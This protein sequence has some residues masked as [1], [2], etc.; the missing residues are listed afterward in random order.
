M[1]RRK[2]LLSLAL[3]L[4]FNLSLFAKDYNA[5]SF[6]AKN[7]G[8][9]LN[10]AIIQGAINYITDHG[11]GRLVFDSGVY[12]TG[13]IYIKSNVT[14]HL[15][16]GAEL[17]SSGNPFD[18]VKDEYAGW[19]SMIF[20]IKQHDIGI[21]GKGTINGMGFITANRVVTYIHRGLINDPLRYDRPEVPNRP[22]NIY[23]RECKNVKITGVTLR[24]PASWNQI[25][26]QCENV[27]IDGIYV[28]SK[29]YWNND[30]ID[31]LNCDGVVIKNSYI[32]A[33]DD[34]LCFKSFD[35][36]G[37]CQNV[38]VDS[39]VVRSSANAIKF[40]TSSRGGFRN[41]KIT[42]IKIFDTYRS[43]VAIEAVDGG[44]VENILID[45]IK[46]Y[47]VGNVIFLRVGD[48]H[49]DDRVPS[50]SN[51][52]IKNVYAEVAASKP[53]S[54]YNYEGPVE[55]LPRN[56]SPSSIVGL[57]QW[58][59]KNV[60]LSNIEIVYPGGGN[61]NYAKVGTSKKELDSI[62]E[63]PYAYPD[64]SQ[65]EELP[66]W[67]FY[68]RHADNIVFDHIQL[69]AK[70]SDYRPAFVFDD[71]K[72]MKLE[73][74]DISEPKAKGKKQIILNNSNRVK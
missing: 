51:V 6:G 39:C 9:T 34:V 3:L 40:G 38:T 15:K 64:F 21:M 11:G 57:P 36:S 32:D 74:I 46:A 60:K 59:I 52:T 16:A 35:P 31:I 61:L 50:F 13:S 37:I 55:D 44:T 65:F 68:V 62:L 47:N 73:D 66:A 53:D 22:V 4:A 24:D 63:M 67:G 12:I 5:S 28:D 10:T 41:F 69:K 30:G 33:A 29:A 2:T 49:T 48:R 7:D 56:I 1:K 70:E 43:V 45:G 71:A 8:V 20:A 19:T 72:N 23:I 42:N 18:F 25:Y 17:R 27:Y 14:L 58:R 26:A 54:G